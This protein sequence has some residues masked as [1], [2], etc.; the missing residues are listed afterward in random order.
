MWTCLRMFWMA[1][2]LRRASSCSKPLK[3]CVQR[4]LS[5]GVSWERPKRADEKLEKSK[6]AAKVPEVPLRRV[7]SCV[8]MCGS[9]AYKGLN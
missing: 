9:D 5:R 4:R 8:L 1:G 6:R 2:V 3:R 7:S